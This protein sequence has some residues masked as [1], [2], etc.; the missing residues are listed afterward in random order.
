MSEI[1][2]KEV[3]AIIKECV[4]EIAREKDILDNSP[5]MDVQGARRIMTDSYR[6][7]RSRLLRLIGQ[8][9][10]DQTRKKSN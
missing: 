4:A 5:L 2:K 7:K 8:I 3:K 9:E 1:T 6:M 10:F